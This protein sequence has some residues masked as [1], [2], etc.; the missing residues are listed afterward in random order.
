MLRTKNI[1][2]HTLNIRM[3]AS[4]ERLSANSF[5]ILLSTSVRLVTMRKATISPDA[6]GSRIVRAITFSPTWV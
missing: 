4:T 5:R 1:L 6:K 3:A 2:L